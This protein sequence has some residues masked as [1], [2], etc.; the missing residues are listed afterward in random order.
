LFHRCRLLLLLL[1]PLLA[2]LLRGWMQSTGHRVLVLNVTHSLHSQTAPHAGPPAA[3]LLLLLLLLLQRRGALLL[4]W[5][6]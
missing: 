1:L 5:R 3:L 6:L 4:S 2:R